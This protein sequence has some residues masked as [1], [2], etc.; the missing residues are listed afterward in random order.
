VRRAALVWL[1]I[2]AAS[3]ATVG[4]PAAPGR[5][6]SEPEAQ[7]LLVAQS[8]VSDGDLDLGDEYGGR[9]WRRFYGGDL[10][11]RAGPRNGR[12][13]DPIGIAFPLLIAPA[14]ALGGATAVEL[15]LAALT[16]VG[17]VLA[18]VLARRVVPEPWA[19]SA[20]LVAGL[21][22]P[23]LVNATTIAPDAV[24]GSVLAG[25]VVLALRVRERPHL[26][27]AFWCATLVAALP[28]LGAKFAAPAIVVALAA[29]RWLHRR[30]RGLAGLVALEVV[31]FSV[32]LYV[33]VDDRLFGGPFPAAL[34]SNP[35]ATGASG[36][37]AHLARAPRLLGLWLDRDVGLLRWAPFAALAFVAIWLLVRSRRERLAVALSG[38]IDVE[39]TAAFYVLVCG[40]TVAFAAF[41]APTIA[42]PWF[43]GHELACI[44]PVGAALAAWGLRRFPRTS[45]AL[46]ALT[47]V[48]S[49][50]LLVAA[51]VDDGG[52]TAPPHGPL[53]WGGVERVLPRLR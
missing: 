18:A 52:G 10:A 41:L 27:L 39:V 45:R 48:A 30:Q 33:T 17:F 31:I 20:A 26:L 49:V 24:A 51:R 28:W 11:P 6:L 34:L 12:L 46:A 2:F 37:G 36:V 35:G 14:Y 8:I 13:L 19:T 29:A 23:A 44:L 38:Q 16:A 21:S 42:G 1:V 22:P 40:A 5:D 15:F 53:P 25:A 43:A 50:W 9:E 32:V 3:A 4:L 7:T 47:L